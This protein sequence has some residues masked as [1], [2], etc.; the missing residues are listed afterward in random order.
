VVAVAAE[1][2]LPNRRCR[3]QWSDPPEIHVVS[4]S[5]H[6]PSTDQQQTAAAQADPEPLLQL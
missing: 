3:R 2:V 1:V 4:P 5:R 6:H